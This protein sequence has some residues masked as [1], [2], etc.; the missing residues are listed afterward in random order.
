MERLVLTLS[1]GPIGLCYQELRLGCAIRNP[2]WIE[3][4][5]APIRL[6]YQDPRLGCAIWY[7]KARLGCAIRIPDWVLLS[8]TPDWAVLSGTLIGLCYQEPRLGVFPNRPDNITNP[9]ASHY[10]RIAINM[11]WQPG[12]DSPIGCCWCLSPIASLL[13]Q[14]GEAPRS[15]I[16]AQNDSD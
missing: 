16:S 8:G 10:S 5:G 12:P 3:L 15:P 14:F 7:H 13:N 4:S 11:L 6:R 2:D 1:G 9:I